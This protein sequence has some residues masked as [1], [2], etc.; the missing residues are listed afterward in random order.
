M[1]KKNLADWEKVVDAGFGNRHN[2]CAWCMKKFKDYI[3]VGTLNFENGCQIYRSSS[4]NKNTWKQVNLDGFDKVYPSTGARTM[5]VYK[6]LLWVVTLC[7]EYGT[8]VWVTNGEDDDNN[9]IKWKK[10]N[11]NGFGD[12]KNTHASR[13][14]VVFKDK[15]YIGTQCR[16][17]VPRIYRYDGSLEFDKLQPEKW[18]WINKDWQDHYNKIPDFSVIG[19]LVNFK[20]PNRKEYIYAGIYSEFI[21][22]FYQFKKSLRFKDFLSLLFFFLLPRCM[23]WR[24]DGISWEKVSKKGFGKPNLLT[25]SSLVYN[26]SIYFGTSNIFGAEIWSS[27]DGISWNRIMKRGFCIPMNI[28]VWSLHIFKNR[29]ILGMQNQWIGSQIWLA[30]NDEPK[31]N[32]DFVQIAQTGM[33]SKIQINPFDIKQDGIKNFETFY[34]YLYAGTSSYMNIVF[35]NHLGPGCEIWR[36]KKV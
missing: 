34:D 2:M 6:N 24:Y 21:G 1:S 23:I 31:N 27:K 33:T 13:A 20:T 8:Q 26:D 12:G 3:Y 22:L 15:L 18:I 29:L 17:G 11:I 35:Y 9:L 32:K 5:I 25:M 30:I 16:K 19:K 10:V 36:T 4:G 7:S 28:S 14:M